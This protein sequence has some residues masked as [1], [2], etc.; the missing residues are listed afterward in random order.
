M[1]ETACWFDMPS[2]TTVASTG[3]KA[4]PV[5]TTGHEKDYF[6]VVLTAHADGKKM[7]P[8]VVF[9]G[10]GTRL[11]KDLQNIPGVL[12]TFSSNGWMNDSLT[13][14]YLQKIIGR[15]SF[16]KR[17]LLWDAY[18]CHTSEATKAEL[19]RLKLDTAVVPGGCTKFIQAADVAWNACFKSHMRGYYDIWLAEPAVHEYTRGGNLKPPSRSLLCQWVKSAWEAVPA[20]TV[21]KSFL[22]CAI[23]TDLDGNDDN[24]IHCFKPN[25]PCHEG[26]IALQQEVA[27]FL[28]SDDDDT[29]DPFVSDDDEEETEN[30]EVL[31]HDDLSDSSGE[32]SDGEASADSD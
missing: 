11:M 21:K 26:R 29:S 3:S 22:S 8:F 15:L 19:G 1:D 24:E 32:E 9:K 30:N 31:I 7:K 20:E 2:D 17:L 14:D 16:S 6:T 28:G 12:V 27:R 18:K 5:K 4:V 10:K 13:A 23:T 25:Q